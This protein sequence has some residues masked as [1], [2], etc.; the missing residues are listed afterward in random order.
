MLKRSFLTALIWHFFCLIFCLIFFWNCSKKEVS[1]LPETI[2]TGELDFSQS[3]G[4]SK[5]EVL[6]SIIKTDDEGYAILGYTQSNDFDITT[7]EVENFDFWLLKHDVNNNLV[8]QQTFGGSMDDRGA[9]LITTSDGGF[10]LLGYSKSAD[11][12]VTSNAGSQDFWMLKISSSG[13]LLWEKTFGFSGPDYGT[14]LIET[15]EGG[16]LVTGV[17]DVSASNGQGNAK[18][19]KQKHAGGDFWALKLTAGG[20]LEWSKYYGGSFTDTPLGVVK[21]ADNGFILVGSSDSNDVDINNN[22]GSYDFWVIKI[23]SDGTLLW[24]K[25]FGGSEIDEARAICATHDGNF[26]V[27]GDTRSS[28][29]DITMNNGGAD[30]W[31][32]KISSEGNLIWEKT[33][34]GT[35]FDVARSISM[36]QDHGFVIAGSSRSGDNDFTNQG[37]NDALVLKIDA[38]GA[39]EWQETIGGSEIDF[40]YDAIELND[41]T[42][43]AVGESS[44]SDGDIS[45]NKGFSDALILQ[46]K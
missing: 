10:A 30:V 21:T 25:S 24:E 45:L 8:W 34:G 20:D 2:I 40:L 18:F 4:G 38:E 28:D 43:I 7:K 41:K 33:F 6:K 3:I 23:S 37:Q 35:S 29:S 19:N 13:N 11:K 42:I 15:E 5:N 12:D 17:L 27:V 36:T 14:T 39:L 1:T 9:K 16:F 26:M 22:K 32:L 31:A 46:I 44:S